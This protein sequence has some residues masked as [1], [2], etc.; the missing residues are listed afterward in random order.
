MNSLAGCISGA[1]SIN[2]ITEMLQNSGFKNIS[3][4][5]KDE[6]KEFIKDWEPGANLED[7]IV[8]AVIKANK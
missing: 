6:S 7:Y 4:E 1:A 8:S 5:A 2:E 3:I